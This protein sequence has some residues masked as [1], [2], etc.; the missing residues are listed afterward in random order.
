MGFGSYKT[1]WSWLHKLRAAMVRSDSEPLGP[2]VQVDE[3]LAKLVGGKGGPHKEL[4]L[5]AA[6]AGGRVRLA[7]VD[8]NDKGTM[9]RFADGQIASDAH[10]VT[11]GHAGYDAK[12]LG[13]RP[14]DAVVQTKAERRDNDAVQGCH[15]TI[16]LLKRWLIGT[17]AGAVRDKHLQ[18]YLDEFAFC[19]NRRKT[20][21]VGRIAAR[22]I[23][24]LVAHPPRTMRQII[25]QSRRCP[26]F[27]SNQAAA[28]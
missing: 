23:E 20:N 11:D 26:W 16:S 18:A 17:H 27:A 2:F 3:A 12:S 13:K 10:V 25:D 14:H 1:A 6:E 24:K 9:K 5:V 7:H 19:H 22:V 8:N 21:G 28:A 4:V 15:W